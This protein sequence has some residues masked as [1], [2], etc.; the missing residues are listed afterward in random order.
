VVWTILLVAGV[1]V[2]ASVVVSLLLFP[3]WESSKARADEPIDAGEI[4]SATS[5][6]GLAG[7]AGLGV[8]PG[9]GDTDPIPSPQRL[10]YAGLVLER[11]AAHAEAVLGVDGACVLV[12]QG[13]QLETV[14]VVAG[15][16]RGKALVGRSFATDSGLSGMALQTGRPVVLPSPGGQEAP[17]PATAIAIEEMCP[18]AAAPLSGSLGPR[19]ALV[20]GAPAASSELGLVEL[21]LLSEFAGL[22]SRALRHDEQRELRGGDSQAE[23]RA[24]VGALA[25]A[26][27]A[28]FRHSLEVAELATRVGRRL[29][30]DRAELVELE[31]GALLHDIGK[32]RLPAEILR[33][34]GPLTA[35]EWRLVQRHP[36]W[37]ADLV[38]GI[39]GLEAVAMIVRLHHER[40]DGA[41]YPH[42]LPH[43]RIPVASR[44]ISVCDAFGAMT[45]GRPYQEPVE[46]RDAIRELLRH[47]GSQFDPESV[48]TLARIVDGRPLAAA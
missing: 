36:E 27:G 21:E 32:L 20:L 46:P 3:L 23:I 17:E 4:L 5:D 25:N 26:D 28:T 33:K 19:G 14:S 43:D 2:V 22:V 11:L 47:S 37:G 41:G 24:L 18:T 10:G 7:P 9:P 48:R 29:G 45:G 34:P 40:P 31:L 30:L 38:A 42:E 1:W 16:G 8:Q 12:R 39:P 13:A 35:D 15:S 6:D 44:I